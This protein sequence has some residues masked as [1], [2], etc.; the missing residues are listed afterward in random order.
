M[1]ISA[2]LFSMLVMALTV[3]VF[4]AAERSDS[5]MRAFRRSFI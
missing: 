2:F 5:H 4:M 3:G 1:A